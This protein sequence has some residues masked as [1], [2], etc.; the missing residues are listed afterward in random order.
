MNASNSII[1]GVHA[2]TDAEPEIRDELS[3]KLI[4]I[5]ARAKTEAKNHNRGADSAPWGVVHEN[6]LFVA[7][8]H[9]I[10]YACSCGAVLSS[11]YFRFPSG[12]LMGDWTVH[13]VQRHRRGISTS[14]I[15]A[16]QFFLAAI[17]ESSWGLS[18][19]VAAKKSKS[20]FIA[21][22]HNDKGSDEHKVHIKCGNCEH[23]G[24]RWVKHAD[25]FL[26]HIVTD[27]DSGEMVL[28][29]KVHV[30]MEG[31]NCSWCGNQFF[32]FRK[33]RKKQ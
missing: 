29:N 33:E 16:L 22:F 15:Q 25:N 9:G 1:L 12:H 21:I 14:E 10:I 32:S 24:L 2:V 11:T 13:C 8:Q 7:G 28:T 19:R 30:K 18:A 6:G 5:L 20:T 23:V 3:F 26:S 31:N 4:D 27:L 17:A